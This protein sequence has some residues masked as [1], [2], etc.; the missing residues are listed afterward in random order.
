MDA[1]T[2]AVELGEALKEVARILRE[3]PTYQVM[4]IWRKEGFQLW[5]PEA[6]MGMQ[7]KILG[8]AD[9]SWMDRASNLIEKVV[10]PK[11]TRPLPFYLYWD[12]ENEHLGIELAKHEEGG[13]IY[14]RIWEELLYTMKKTKSDEPMS[15]KIREDLIKVR[16]EGQKE[17]PVHVE[18][19]WAKTRDAL[20]ENGLR[21]E[22]GEDPTLKIVRIEG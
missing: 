3:H 4:Y 10:V 11:L 2:G 20:A 9:W 15:G 22:D 18:A 8:E 13:T 12:R 5:D 19:L 1:T 21:L 7:G 17:L 6:A 16:E 14:G